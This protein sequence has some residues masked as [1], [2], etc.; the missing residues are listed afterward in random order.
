[1][2]NKDVQKWNRRA[3]AQDKINYSER[4]TP[5]ERTQDF[6]VERILKE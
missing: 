2:K 3:K 5:H 6:E 4:E 1:M